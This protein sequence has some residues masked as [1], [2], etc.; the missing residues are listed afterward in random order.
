LEL[1]CKAIEPK[2]K[3]L[4]AWSWDPW[5]PRGAKIKWSAHHQGCDSGVREKGLP[6]ATTRA[7]GAMAEGTFY[8]YF[9]RRTELICAAIEEVASTWAEQLRALPK[10]VGKEPGV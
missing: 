2:H 8:L 10:L 3:L 7:I 6:G 1:A 5:G 9:R 4:S